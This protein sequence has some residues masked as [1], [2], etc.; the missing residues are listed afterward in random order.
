[1][2]KQNLKPNEE[3]IP[4]WADRFLSWYC[5]PELLEEVQGDIHEMFF[6]RCEKDNIKK[7][8]LYFVIDVFR[9]F[10]YS[11]IK[12]SRK[13]FQIYK[14]NAMLYN[15]LK[16]AIRNLVKEQLYTIVNLSGL[17]IALA[18]AILIS[19]FV[20]D[21]WSFDK[22]HTQSDRIYRAWVKEDHG[23]NEIYFNTF[24]PPIL[25]TTLKSA[26]PEASG[27]IRLAQFSTILKRDDYSDS[28]QVLLAERGFFD[29]FDFK[30]I[31]GKSSNFLTEPSQVILSESA[32]AK[33]FDTVDVIG[34]LLTIDIDG[35]ATPFTVVGII[36]NAPKNSSIQYE[37]II[38]YKNF[39]YISSQRSRESWYN[40]S[41]ETYLLMHE[42]V[43]PERLSEKVGGIVK[44]LLGDKYPENG[45]KVG[46]QSLAD[47]H[48]NSD[49]PLGIAQISD[50]KYSYILA[51]IAIF[52]LLVAAINFM[53]LSIG[54]SLK[55]AKEVGVRKSIGA[56]R[57]QI[58]AQYWSEAVLTA[59]LAMLLGIVV[60]LIS[61]PVFNS[62]TSKQLELEFNW[63]NCAIVLTITLFTGLISGLYPALVL[64]R[65]SPVSVLKGSL[66]GSASSKGTNFFRKLMVSI[67]FVLSVML[68]SGTLIMREQLHFLQ[69]K[70]LGF[71]EEK[72]MVIPQFINVLQLEAITPGMEKGRL[73]KEAIL[74]MPEVQ[75]ATVSIHSFDQDGWLE[76]GYKD[77]KDIMQFFHFNVIDEAFLATHDIQVL[78]GRNLTKEIVSDQ[79]SAM[80]INETMAK[81][82]GWEVG[83]HPE[84]YSDY[85]VIG[86]VKDF[87]FTSL[88]TPIKPVM[89]VINPTGIFQNIDNIESNSSIVPK[90]TL[91]LQTQDFTHTVDKLETAYKKLYPEAIFDFTFV[92]EALNAM[93]KKEQQMGSILNYATFIGLFI[94]CLGLFGL[95]TLVVN[96]RTKEI[97]IRKVLGAPVG[98]ILIQIYKEFILLVFLALLFA[99]PLTWLIMENW[100]VD[101]SFR[102][103]IN[104]WIF[105]MAGIIMLLVTGITIS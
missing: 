72:L 92:D 9:F 3:H 8:R 81:T 86:I 79:R 82:F 46:F 100:L 20:K 65:S 52:I 61:L 60:A 2:D 80:L 95:I 78:R 41:V 54:R 50:W 31:K 19:L 93:Y 45:Y 40:V 21:E 77:E 94:A 96:K 103:D 30:T 83:D 63:E 85:E 91:K 105:L 23:N 17:A 53:T 59:F 28:E 27:V 64:S 16:V 22:F 99:T 101:F 51:T 24:T 38:P 43:S 35:E 55:R 71:N 5:A 48:L 13:F 89:L 10:N 39:E 56:Q 44:S 102:I 1:M 90:V 47:I 73:L 57:K 4:L 84:Q 26:V 32:V 6:R 25:G 87:H 14:S 97:G 67:Q 33:Y 98:S 104:P 42:G 70:N 29:V 62:F 12:G 36:E 58:I 66:G 11:T 49:M 15:Y 18:C 68:V 37:V 75:T 74:K 69:N 7:A 34:R 88:H 76:L